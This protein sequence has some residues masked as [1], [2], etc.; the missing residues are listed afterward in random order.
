[1][2]LLLTSEMHFYLVK[3][4]LR[5]QLASLLQTTV[6]TWQVVGLALLSFPR[7]G[8]LTRFADGCEC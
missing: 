2:A 3:G 1:M 6:S 5:N 7:L 8:H 4:E